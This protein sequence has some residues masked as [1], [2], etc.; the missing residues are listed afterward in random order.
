MFSRHLVAASNVGS[1][2][3]TIFTSQIAPFRNTQGHQAE[4]IDELVDILS[5]CGWICEARL[6]TNG[7]EQR[8][9]RFEA[10]VIYTPL[11][12][13]PQVALQLHSAAESQKSRIDLEVL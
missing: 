3:D 7:L 8:Q 9:L 2:I 4:L 12:H 13:E 1:G 11:E 10:L 6:N 5:H